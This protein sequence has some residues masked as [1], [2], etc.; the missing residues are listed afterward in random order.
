LFPEAKGQIVVRLGKTWILFDGLLKLRLG[1]RKLFRF[2]QSHTLI[3]HGNCLAFGLDDWLPGTSGTSTS[4]SEAR[5]NRQRGDGTYSHHVFH[6]SLQ[7][8]S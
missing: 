3:V 8:L 7:F 1:A 5:Q 6:F 4:G 2:H